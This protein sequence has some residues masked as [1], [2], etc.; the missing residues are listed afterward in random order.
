M[1]V[2]KVMISILLILLISTML[3]A[4]KN[5]YRAEKTVNSWVNIQQLP[6]DSGQLTSSEQSMAECNL[7]DA[8]TYDHPGTGY[9]IGSTPLFGKSGEDSTIVTP[10]G[11]DPGPFPW[12]QIFT[13]LIGLLTTVITWVV[14]KYL[15]IPITESQVNPII[16]YVF[17][18]IAAQYLKRKEKPGTISG[19]DANK[20]V[21]SAV[22]DLS[23]AKQSLLVNKFGSLVAAVESIYREKFLPTLATSS[24]SVIR[25]KALA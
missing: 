5:S 23:Y 15:K 16:S 14:V 22:N 20:A 21:M 12:K 8:T 11:T 6:V 7:Q 4:E 1:K 17:N 25:S 13:F 18:L 10:P 9:A 2:M 19:K 3:M 24:G